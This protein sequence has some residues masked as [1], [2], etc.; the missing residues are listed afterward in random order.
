MITTRREVNIDNGGTALKSRTVKRIAPEEKYVSISPE[1]EVKPFRETASQTGV[2][3][4]SGAEKAQEMRITPKMD[5]G[6]LMPVIKS[7]DAAEENEQKEAQKLSSKAK[8]M[9]CVYLA[10]ALILALIVLATGLAIT[11]TSKEVAALENEVK[12]QSA[13]LAESEAM[14]SHLSDDL[15]ITGAATELGM[16]KTDEAAKIELLKISDKTSYE[17][18]TNAFD[19]FCDFLSGIIGG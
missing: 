17:E 9:L 7:E 16:V 15:T 11:G 5:L 12:T 10:T 1:V 13:M 19:R 4:V 14:L 3:T 2:S 6:D 18:R 8:I